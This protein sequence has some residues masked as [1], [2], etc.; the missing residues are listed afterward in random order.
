M[1]LPRK[2]FHAKIDAWQGAIGEFLYSIWRKG[3]KLFLRSVLKRT[4]ALGQRNL[5]SRLEFS[6]TILAAEG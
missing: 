3:S 1:W 2:V 5:I 6:D 4:A